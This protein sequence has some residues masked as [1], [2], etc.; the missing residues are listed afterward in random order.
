VNIIQQQITNEFKSSHHLTSHV[1]EDI[2]NSGLS[3]LV[4]E[5]IELLTN[6]VKE[7]KYTYIVGEE[8]REWTTKKD[9]HINLMQMDLE[10][11]VWKVL[12]VC[13]ATEVQTFTQCV[14]MIK[15]L[16]KNDTVRQD[17]EQSSECIT[18]LAMLNAV[19]IKLPRD[20]EEGVL[21]VYSKIKYANDLQDFLT[22]TSHVLPSLTKPKEIKTNKCSGYT[23][24]ESSLILGGKYHKFP[25]PLDHINRVNSVALSLN[26]TPLEIEPTF[27]EKETETTEERNDRYAAWKQLNVESMK[28]Y[29][30]LV[31]SGNKFYL[32]YKYCERLRTYAHGYQVSTQGDSYRKSVLELANK[33]IV[34]M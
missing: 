33:E 26:T 1:Q 30:D 2:T 25:V 32:T 17:I 16:F 27:K 18:L 31:K 13:T 5:Y 14:G 29:A 23:T 6:H 8:T 3:N 9:R 12:A 24:F 21:M 10:E 22:N 7:S 34:E 20:T 19:D 11:L 28:T 15:G 4:P